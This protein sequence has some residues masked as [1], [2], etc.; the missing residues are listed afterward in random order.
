VQKESII[1]SS[2][3]SAI[4]SFRSLWKNDDIGLQLASY[5]GPTQLSVV[6]HTESDGKLGGASVRG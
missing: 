5:L 6:Y 3:V 1:Q 4:H 2:E